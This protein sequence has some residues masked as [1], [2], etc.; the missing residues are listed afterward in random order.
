MTH[1]ESCDQ[2]ATLWEVRCMWGGIWEY[3]NL[4]TQGLD[5]GHPELL[6]WRYV[7]TDVKEDLSC[8]LYNLMNSIISI[9]SLLATTLI[10]LLI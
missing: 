3:L 8:G 7:D 2:I 1:K 4:T 5:D 6:F 10:S 9:I